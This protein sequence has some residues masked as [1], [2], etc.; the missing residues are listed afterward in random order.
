MRLR[1]AGKSSRSRP[2]ARVVT[3]GRAAAA[4]WSSRYH[5]MASWPRLTLPSDEAVE[6]A[7]DEDDDESDESEED[8]EINR[9]LGISASGLVGPTTPSR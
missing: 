6:V 5:G 3:V 2:S 8:E 1:R 7:E 4:E 9:L